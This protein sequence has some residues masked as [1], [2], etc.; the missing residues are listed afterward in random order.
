MSQSDR[1]CSDVVSH[2]HASGVNFLA[3]DFDDTLI[4]GH[5]FGQ[6]P[7]SA[8]D[9]A[10]K[11]RPLFRSLIPVAILNG[12]HVAIVTFSPQVPLIRQTLLHQFPEF[13]DNIPIRGRDDTWEYHGDGAPEGKQKHIASVAEEINSNEL[14]N[15][16]SG[17][18]INILSGQKESSSSSN[19][20]SSSKI[21]RSTTLLIDDDINNVYAA[22]KNKV[23]AILCS[24]Q[25]DDPERQLID[26]LLH[27]E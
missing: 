24:P 19:T 5:T 27:I 3:I 11:I 13:A 1:I 2:L 7:G 20:S 8:V 25:H 15:V 16:R 17:N 10:A 9:L 22:L 21:T 12:L 18:A 4:Q 14:E 23:R 26:D 6:W